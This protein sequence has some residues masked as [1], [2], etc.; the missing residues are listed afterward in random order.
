M[1]AAYTPWTRHLTL[2]TAR[3][4][5]KCAANNITV[6][7]GFLLRPGVMTDMASPY[8]GDALTNL[9]T[10]A[11]MCLWEAYDSA[12]TDISGTNLVVGWADYQNRVIR[13]FIVVP[14]NG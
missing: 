1:T 7:N 4:E 5:L 9:G 2:V 14:Q 11:P 13:A 6:T 12:A 8:P 10:L 3:S